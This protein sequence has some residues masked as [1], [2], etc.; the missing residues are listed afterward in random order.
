MRGSSGS[1]C[2][3]CLALT[4]TRRSWRSSSTN[5]GGGRN[6]YQVWRHGSTLPTTPQVGS[7]FGQSSRSGAVVS[8]SSSFRL[9]SSREEEIAKLEEQ[10]RKLRL[11]E[12]QVGDD[13]ATSAT[14]ITTSRSPTTT[15]AAETLTLE[16]Q[17]IV[18]RLERIQGKDML[19]SER[20][21][22]GDGIVEHAAGDGTA[23]GG[24]VALQA[25]GAILGLGLLLAFAQVP[26]GREGLA[27]YSATGSSV[28]KTID[29]GDLNPDAPKP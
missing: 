16:E 9:F 7:C 12:P 26:V 6:C 19:L 1:Q 25:V 3:W 8:S 28:V 21:L 24:T 17:V 22:I 11:D 10:L 2:C 15:A 5:V 27:Q 13:E 18:A 14:T 20:E 29:L 4:P 23:S